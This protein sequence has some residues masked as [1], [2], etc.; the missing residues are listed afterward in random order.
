MRLA[1][2]RRTCVGALTRRQANR[3]QLNRNVQSNL[4]THPEAQHVVTLIPNTEGAIQNLRPDDDMEAPSSALRQPVPT[5]EQ[6][7]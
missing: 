2:Y 7:S 6:L 4:G 1:G 5:S 3:V